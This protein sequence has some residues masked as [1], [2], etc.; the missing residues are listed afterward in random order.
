MKSTP[1]LGGTFDDWVAHYEAATGLPFRFLAGESLL[2]DPQHGFATFGHSSARDA[3][4]VG[5]V[6]GAS[7]FWHRELTNLA[8]LFG[9]PKLRGTA[10]SPSRVRLFRRAHGARVVGYVMETE[11]E[12]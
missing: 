12:P 2:F 5:K 9:Y 1:P 4:E 10:C 6:C 11:V 7:A 3:L 8:R